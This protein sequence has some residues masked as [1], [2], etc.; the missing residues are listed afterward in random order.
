M[1]TSAQWQSRNSPE[2]SGTDLRANLEN[3]IEFVKLMTRQRLTLVTSRFV[4]SRN[5]PAL[6]AQTFFC[7]YTY[8]TPVRQLSYIFA[9]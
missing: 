1:K 3:K 9:S 2:H 5:L 4:T 8:R 6:G 7:A